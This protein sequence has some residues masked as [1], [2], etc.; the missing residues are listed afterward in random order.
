MM[1]KTIEIMHTEKNREKIQKLA[2]T[3]ENYFLLF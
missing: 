1:G 2:K 3:G